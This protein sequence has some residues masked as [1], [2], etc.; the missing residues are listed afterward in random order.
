M[1][2]N[3]TPI[4][5]FAFGHSASSI[6][7]RDDAQEAE[8][9]LQRA[10]VQL[11][12]DYQSHWLLFQ[13]LQQQGK[14]DEAKEQLKRAE[15]VR[16]RNERLGELTSRKL[17][18]NPLDPG[19]HYEFGTILMRDGRTQSALQWF[20]SALSLDPNHRPTHAGWRITTKRMAT[21]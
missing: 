21:S 13:A 18:E 6:Y 15:M 5:V 4:M 2:S 1:L 19:I 9:A 14:L 12:N 17:A 3:S 7:R 11:P 16:D 10:V 8:L 20:D